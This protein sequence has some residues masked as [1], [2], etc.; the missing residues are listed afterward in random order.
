MLM[1]NN[2]VLTSQKAAAQNFAHTNFYDTQIP[3][4]DC[5]PNAN[6]LSWN[7]FETK[8]NTCKQKQ[9]Q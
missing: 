9:K 3:T 4:L 8:V 2:T 6:L 5:H 1:L 7:P